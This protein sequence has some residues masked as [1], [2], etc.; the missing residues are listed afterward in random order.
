MTSIDLAGTRA[1]FGPRAAGWEDRFAN[2]GPTYERAVAELAPPIGGTA[3]DAAC[4]TG[5]ALPALRDQVGATGTIIAVDVTVEMLTEAA[6]RGRDSLA[7]LLIADVTHL[8]LGTATI[9]AIFA[10]GLLP[11]LPD[12]A[13]GL[14]ELARVTRPGGRLALFHPIG[15]ASLAHRHG[16]ELQPDDIRAEPNIRPALARAGWRCESV[17]DASGRYFV[18]AARNNH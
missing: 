18:L 11:H 2:D 3:L 5:R 17:D 13:T 14:A 6:R 16:H 15:R 8:P 9:D 12:P 10:A 4:G 7:A 1:F